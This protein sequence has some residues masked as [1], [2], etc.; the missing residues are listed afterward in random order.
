VMTLF[1]LSSPPAH[2][3]GTGLPF[4]VG[5]DP[6]ATAS[7]SSRLSKGVMLAQ[8]NSPHFNGTNPY[9]VAVVYLRL[10]RVGAT[11]TEIEDLD[12]RIQNLEKRYDFAW[13]SSALPVKAPSPAPGSD[14]FT[15]RML[16]RRSDIRA[17]S[18]EPGVMKVQPISAYPF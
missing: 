2:S 18:R 11:M 7:L 14:Y 15:V 10:L 5:K 13:D 8:N 1:A 9:V 17:L 3:Q 16:L 12:A 6:T 4:S